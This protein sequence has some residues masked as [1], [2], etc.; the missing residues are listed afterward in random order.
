MKESDMRRR[1]FSWLAY[2]A[3]LQTAAFAQLIPNDAQFHKQWALYN[4]GTFHPFTGNPNV[5][6]GADMDMPKAWAIET[7]DSS[8]IAAIIDT[9]CKWKHKEFEGRIWKNRHEVPGN[10]IDDDGNGYVDDSIGWNFVSNNGDISDNHGHGTGMAAIIGANGNNGIGFAGMDWKCKLMIC[11]VKDTADLA[12]NQN[13][14]KAIRYA[15]DNGARIINLSLSGKSNSDALTSAV[16]YAQSRNV[17]LVAGA[18]NEGVDS[19]FYPARFD[20]CLAVGSTDS[21]DSFSR[22]FLSGGGSNY[23][24]DIDVVAPGNF[25]YTLDYLADTEY[26]Y[27]TGGTSNSTAYV[28]GLAALLL[29]QDPTRT[30]ATLR[31]LIQETADDQVGKPTEDTPGW[32]RF[33]GY[34]RVNAFR[35]LSAIKSAIRIAAAHD[36]TMPKAGILFPSSLSG[37]AFAFEPGQTVGIWDLKGRKLV[38][39][40][41]AASA[42]SRAGSRRGGPVVF[43]LD[44]NRP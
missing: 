25:I 28:S 10:Q 7:G 19:V 13:V 22:T 31:S 38:R 35:A 11:K 23:G 26:D 32:D 15:V 5:K 9:G 8:I 2:L 12:L 44:A 29:A 33:H 17:F 3:G 36:R 20:F 39:L 14:A 16:Q 34:G 4:D 1:F 27:I 6:V 24:N 41:Q 37:G 42:A 18:G 30:P 40:E 43:A 21:D